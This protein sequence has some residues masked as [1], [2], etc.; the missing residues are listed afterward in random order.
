MQIFQ[1]SVIQRFLQSLDKEKLQ[2]AYKV[3]KLNYSPEKIEKIKNLKEE[4][5]QDGF[6]R[7]IFVDVFG[8]T[9]KPNENHNLVREFK[10]QADS[11]KADGAILIDETAIAVIELKSTK[12][13]D[14]TSISQQAFNYKN[15]QPGCKYVIISNFHK[16]RFYID[17]A[18][19]FE[20]FDLFNLSKEQF[21]LLYLILS[22]Q[23]I[24][25]GIPLTLKTETRFHEQDVSDKLY[26]D[27]SSFKHSIFNNLVKNNPEIDKLLLF[28]KSQKLLDRLLFIFFAEDS[29]LLPD[30]SI[31]RM[32]ERHQLLIDEDAYKPL[33]DIY[34]QYFGYMNIGRK[35]KVSADDIPAYNGGLFAP[36][37]ILDIVIIDDNVLKDYSLK[38]S[39]YNFSTEVDV[40][41]L[42]HI[43][44]H[45]LSEIEEIENQ[46]AEN[47][48][49]AK[50]SK[51]KKDGVFYTPKYIT[52]YIVE[53]TIGKL[54]TEKRKEMQI[55]EIE[56]DDSFRTKKGLSLKGKELFEK[57]N[58]YKAWLLTLK[59]LD[60]ACGSGAFLNQA[61]QFLIA[62]H[63]LI[64][65]VI[66]D[67][68]GKTEALRIFDT[69][70]AIL[71]NNIY[72]VDI[73][74]ESV[75]IA[76]LSLWLRTAQR[77]RKLSIL[78]NNIKCGNSLIDDPEVAGDKA[79]DW[80]I[81]FKD[82]MDNGGFD[83][84]IGNPPYV[85]INTMPDIHDY[86]KRSYSSIH[87]GHNDLMY[88]FLYKGI[89]ILRPKG[90]YGVITSN[91]FIG[92]DY[93]AKLRVFLNK[94]INVIV[95]FEKTL[96]FEDANVHT[97]IIFASKNTENPFIQFYTYT[98]NRPLAMVDTK[99]GYSMCELDRGKIMEKW[100]I[101]D[102]ENQLIIDKLHIDSIFLNDICIIEQ[103]SKSGKNEIF[104]I[105]Y[106]LAESLTFEPELLRK[107]VKNGDIN[108][109]SFKERGNY[110]IYTDNSTV[111]NKY[112][113][114]YN[115]LLR[116]E[117]ELSSRNEA[118]KGLYSWYRLDRPRNKK[119]FDA[120]E[121]IIVPYRSVNNR[122]AYDN[123]Q[124]FNDGGDIRA[125]VMKEKVQFSI[126][127]ILTLLNSKLIDWFYGFIGKPKGN[128]REYFNQPLSE[129]PIKILSFIYQ[130]A[131][132]VLADIMISSL[133]ELH[134]E[135]E[136]FINALKE[137]KGIENITRNIDNF[138]EL[139]YDEFKK[140]LLKQKVKISLGN[141][142]NEWREYFNSTK[143]KVNDLVHKINQ[144]DKEIDKMVYELYE[145]TEEEIEIVENSIK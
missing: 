31:S 47:L 5:Y 12:T 138:N 127:F 33:Y 104:T 120:K 83:V 57:L 77:G 6:L 118:A 29:Q 9:L 94:H 61:L 21:D 105:P 66:A 59:I 20:E 87:T 54:C 36:D 91:Y 63:K 62:E 86:L 128:S 50:T 78:N 25:D 70:K 49:E 79:F 17:Y 82:I 99:K 27:Y 65:D 129:I 40:N 130:E 39:E 109:Y 74:D 28:K 7:D 115:Y 38:L 132:I 143:Q 64:D 67:L 53:N 71:E 139:E 11:K 48:T 1:N 123:R 92:N 114:V 140:E 41:I 51:R 125:I 107:N 60:P 98:E 73:N 34:K 80:N 76:K 84:V 4:E 102:S 69:D 81:E 145:L 43:F 14:L 42:G 137:N 15:N 30:N 45:S 108:R 22:K 23:S 2:Q 90:I 8:Y 95:N 3:F 103:G 85:N 144:T 110:L 131:F 10:N 116:F 44:E 32:I 26:K 97:T 16:L 111:I 133:S 58:A 56:F 142:N 55:Y 93:A 24:F 100:L 135:K 88:Y 122:F 117:N 35:G 75:E 89:S 101:A 112:P 96:I 13:K 106:N 19:E 46:L 119:I 68:E 18:N 52:Q 134:T 141:E 37:D 121:K 136:N 113:N 124:F 126:K 72:G